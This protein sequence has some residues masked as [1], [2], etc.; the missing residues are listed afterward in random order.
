MLVTGTLEGNGYSIRANGEDAGA[1][2][3][4]GGGGGAG[5]T[6]LLDVTTYSGT[7]GIYATGGDGG[8]TDDNCTGSG[9]G[10]SGGVLWYSG[11]SIPGSVTGNI[12]EGQKG[13]VSFACA[14]HSGNNG[15]SGQQLTDLLM[16]LN[17]FLFNTIKGVDTLCAGQVPALLTGSQPKGGDGNYSFAWEQSTDQVNW[18]NAV[19][20][21]SLLNMQ[22][23]AL[24]A[25][26]YYRRIVLSDTI[27]DTSRVVEI[28]VYP[29]ISNNSISGSDTICYGLNAT[30]LTGLQ[31]AGGDNSY[32]FQWQL[33]TDLSGW[34]NTGVPQNS[35]DPFDPGALTVTSYYRR[36]V[37]ST[38]YCADTSNNITITVLPSITNNVFA[39]PDTVICENLGP[40]LVNAATPA[41]GDGNYDYLWQDR[42][43]TGSWQDIPGSNV[44]RYDPG[45]LD[46]TMLYRRIVRSGN[47]DACVDTST[48]KTIEVLPLIVNNLIGTDSSRYCA[49]RR[50]RGRYVQLPMGMAHFG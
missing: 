17:G 36:V 35:N 2:T 26:T 1:A 22:P 21:S 12:S 5:G 25:T 29:D 33:S 40:G 18:I 19:G 43:E 34:N 47:D 42:T 50:C 32:T 30:A 48:F 41:G 46:E 9:G 38:A 11:T 49:F 10:G 28:F 15:S 39:T 8:H 23:E 4:S 31:P 7:A 20:T 37:T 13:T 24:F 44:L 27:V 6:I 14:G 3:G 16:P 45:I